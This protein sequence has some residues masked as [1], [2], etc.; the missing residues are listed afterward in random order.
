LATL[1]G[2]LRA[3]LVGLV[4]GL[5]T[6]GWRR[7]GPGRWPLAG[8]GSARRVSARWPA[9]PARTAGAETLCDPVGRQLTGWAGPLHASRCRPP[10]GG[11]GAAGRSRPPPA[12]APPGREAR[13]PGWWSSPGSAW[14]SGRCAPGRTCGHAPARPGPGPGAGAGAGPPRPR[15]FGGRVRAGPAGP[16]RGRR[17]RA[18]S[19]AGFGCRGR[20]SWCWVGCSPDQAAT[21]TVP[22]WSSV[23]ARAAVAAGQVAGSAKATLAPWRRGRPAPGGRGGGSAEEQRS[24]LSRTSTATRALARSSDSWAGRSRRRTP[25]AVA[26]RWWPAAQQRADLHGRGVVGVLCRLQPAGVHR[27]GPG[28][29]REAQPAGPLERPAGHDRLAS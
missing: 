21:V 23:Q 20:G 7:A 16:G 1:V 18:R 19:A 22:S 29:P 13:P 11:P 27:G 8:R 9:S 3:F 2:F 5:L 14:R 6:A 28:V 26:P 10:A 15:H 17:C 4:A 12:T 24:D 25:T